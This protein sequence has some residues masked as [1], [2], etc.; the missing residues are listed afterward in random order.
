[1]T[2]YITAKNDRRR[3]RTAR[4][5]TAA[6]TLTLMALAAYSFG[7]FDALLAPEEAEVI[8]TTVANV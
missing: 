1:M 3:R 8:A 6:I 4:L 5:L 7:A 2:N